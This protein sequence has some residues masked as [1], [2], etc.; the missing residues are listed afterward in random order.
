MSKLFKNRKLITLSIASL[1]L[2]IG[3]II[4][5]IAINSNNKKTPPR[6]VYN[7][8]HYIT[9]QEAIT[10]SSLASQY[11]KMNTLYTAN[12]A[13]ISAT[14]ITFDTNKKI[15]IESAMDFYAFTV[16][17]NS[18]NAFLGYKYELLAN[19]DMKD[20]YTV[21]PIGYQNKVFNGSFNGNGHTIKNLDLQTVVSSNAS[22][23]TDTHYYALFCQNN[24]TVANFGLID[25]KISI[26]TT[27]AENESASGI[28]YVSNVV[29]KNTGEVSYVF[30]RDN[31]E[32]DKKK[33]PGIDLIEAGFHMSGL[34]AVNASGARF[35]NSYYASSTVISSNNTKPAEFQEVLLE[36][37]GT[38]TIS[39]LFFYNSSIEE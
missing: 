13:N 26:N 16:L 4:A 38:G 34:V 31:Q 36:N 19:I 11:V 15:A 22:N 14:S 23:F 7:S 20:A 2:I 18:T 33:V 1:F 24:G 29:G 35:N 28:F 3:T 8:G 27:P 6:F 32:E 10:T 37:R 25:P 21:Y 5:I 9:N 12:G 17:A 30:V 39:N